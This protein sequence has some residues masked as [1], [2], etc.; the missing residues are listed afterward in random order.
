MTV[1]WYDE[2]HN[3]RA[4]KERQ[5][6]EEMHFRKRRIQNIKKWQAM[7]LVMNR[8]PPLQS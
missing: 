2:Y 6:L 4:R 1:D 7:P 3:E 8:A 5:R